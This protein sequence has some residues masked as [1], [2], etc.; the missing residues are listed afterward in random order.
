MKEKIIAVVGT[1]NFENA[2]GYHEN[3]IGYSPSGE[4]CGERMKSTCKGCTRAIIGNTVTRSDSE[5]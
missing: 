4:W 5:R 2:D 1:H 3:G